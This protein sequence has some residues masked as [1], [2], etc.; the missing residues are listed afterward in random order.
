MDHRWDL[1]QA[2][3]RC[4]ENQLK[5]KIYAGEAGHREEFAQGRVRQVSLLVIKGTPFFKTSMEL[6]Y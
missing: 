2:F 1:P 4:S 3:S 5:K 6:N